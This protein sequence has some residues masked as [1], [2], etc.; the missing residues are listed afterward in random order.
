MDEIWRRRPATEGRTAEGGIPPW[1]LGELQH[2]EDVVAV[3]AEGKKNE[4][5]RARGQWR[6]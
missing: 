6:H 5:L 1:R 4:R 3:A 2:P